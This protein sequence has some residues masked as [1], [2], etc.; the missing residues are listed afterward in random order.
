MYAQANLSETLEG[1]LLER[2]ISL[3]PSLLEFLK[4]ALSPDISDRPKDFHTL[5]DSH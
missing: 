5:L 3:N 1:R 2:G 4:S